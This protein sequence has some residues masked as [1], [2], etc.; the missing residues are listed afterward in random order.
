[1]RRRNF[2]RLLGGAAGDVCIDCVHFVASGGRTGLEHQPE[3]SP[4][5][6]AAPWGPEW[7]LGE[8]RYLILGRG[9]RAPSI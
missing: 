8:S 1:M 9:I 6:I 5:A 2:I 3:W 7:G 4:A